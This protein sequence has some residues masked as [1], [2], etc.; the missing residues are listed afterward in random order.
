MIRDD[1]KRSVLAG[2]TGKN[3]IFVIAV[4]MTFIRIKPGLQIHSIDAADGFKIDLNPGRAD[5]RS[6]GSVIAIDSF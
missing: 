5:G 1:C 2:G 6:P 3:L 4:G